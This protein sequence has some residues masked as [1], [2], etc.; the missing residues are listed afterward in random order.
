MS[1]ELLG[2]IAAWN[3]FAFGALLMALQLVSY[4]LGFVLGKRRRARGDVEPE[5]VGVI[6]GGIMG[7]LGF[8]LAL[9]LSFANGRFEER[10]GGTLAE[11]N[12]IGTAW[13]RAEAVGHQRGPLISALLEEYTH[14]R[15]D[16][17]RAEADGPTLQKLIA[18]TNAVQSEI[19]GHVTAIV[20]EQPT[21]ISASLM[22]SVNDTFDMSTASRFSYEMRVPSQ[23][24]WL[25]LGMSAAAMAALGYQLALRGKPVGGMVLLLTLTWTVVIVDIFDLAAPRLGA[26]RTSTAVYEWTIQGFKGGISIPPLPAR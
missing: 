8:V 19:W 25:L 3:F 21:P 5:G 10:R 11:A 16:Y 12:A 17:V 13:L 23:I 20:R 24:L 6:V 22:A 1:I 9:T 2:Q 14:L 18:R 15:R 26:M 7:L 4:G